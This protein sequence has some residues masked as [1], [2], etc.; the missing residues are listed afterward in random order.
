[1]GK[2]DK[3]IKHWDEQIKLNDELIHADASGIMVFR[4][5]GKGIVEKLKSINEHLRVIVA[6]YKAKNDS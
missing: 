1:M 2:F 6:A 5:L 3:E 4:G